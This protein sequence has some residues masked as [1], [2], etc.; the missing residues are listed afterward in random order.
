MKICVL[1]DVMAKGPAADA[2]GALQ[3]WGFLCNPWDEDDEKDDQR[4]IFPS[5]EAPV[6]WNWQ[7]KTEILPGGGGRFQYHFVHHN[8]HM[9]PVPVTLYPPQIPHGL[10]SDRTQASAILR[11]VTPYR[12]VCD[13][14]P[15]DAAYTYNKTWAS[16]FGK[17]CFYGQTVFH[18]HVN[19]F[20]GRFR[21]LVANF[22][23][24]FCR[25]AS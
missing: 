24:K 15:A 18:I 7:G 20:L 10:T 6:E 21:S 23:L 1:P 17:I 9:K 11:D 5:N 4:F 22:R 2:S 14:L 16:V 12:L 13:C 8:S 3:P 19:S 25:A